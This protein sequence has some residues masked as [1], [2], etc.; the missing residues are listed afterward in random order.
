MKIERVD[1][2]L[3]IRDK[4][5]LNEFKLNPSAER[6][7]G[8]GGIRRIRGVVQAGGAFVENSV[9]RCFRGIPDTP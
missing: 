7:V 8:R 9:K 2:R 1:V 5:E 4:D 6:S 3:K